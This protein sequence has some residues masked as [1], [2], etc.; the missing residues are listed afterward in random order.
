MT[1][2]KLGASLGRGGYAEV[3]RA[4][5]RDGSGGTVALKRGLRETRE[6]I[7]RL[8]REIEVQQELDHPN[9]MPILDADILEGWYTMPLASG[10]LLK[11]VH[12]GRLPGSP[13]DVALDLVGQVSRGLEHAHTAGYVHRD[14]T[15]GNI[16]AFDEDDGSVRWVVADWGLVR[17]PRGM[18]SHPLTGDQ[19]LG[20]AGFA[21]PE[22]YEGYAHEAD[23]PCDVYSLGR[24]IAWLLTGR[25]PQPNLSLRVDGPLRGF[26]AECTDLNPDRR[27]ETM[28][29]MRERLREL[30]AEPELGT[31]GQVQMILEGADHDPDAASRAIAIGLREAEDDEIWADEIARVP[32]EQVASFAR[33][34]PERAAEAAS[35]MLSHLTSRAWGHRDF[36]Y[37]NTPLRWAHEVLRVL[38]ETGELDLAEELAVSFFERDEQWNRFRQKGIT[39]SWLRSLEEPEG[40]VMRS[41][42]RRARA[43]DY[44]RDAMGAGSILSRS[45]AA[46]FG[47]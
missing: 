35:V 32:L 18:T 46:E 21:A 36:N 20:T 42:L 29:A 17:R 7:A 43:G 6:G 28:E 30:T 5:R 15:P 3:F 33:L 8:K 47:R 45:L 37:L 38:T 24:V 11:L 1:T 10:S 2:Y 40:R 14:V 25:Q 9:V 27:P 16:L 31:R 22:T 26:I 39:V 41:A 12:E 13:E 19:G 23:L 34:E 4:E 44:Y